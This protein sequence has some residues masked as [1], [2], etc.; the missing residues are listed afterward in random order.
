MVFQQDNPFQP[1][2]SQRKEAP[3]LK[4]ISLAKSSR[5]GEKRR[6]RLIKKPDALIIWGAMDIRLKVH[7][8][9]FEGVSFK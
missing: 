4:N 2:L 8:Q 7:V 3:L 5:R 6:E 9:D 1:N